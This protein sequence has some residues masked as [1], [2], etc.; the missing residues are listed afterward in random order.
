MSDDGYNIYGVITGTLGL[1]ALF[2]LTWIYTQLPWRK[3]AALQSFMDRTEATF[4]KGLGQA[5]HT[6]EEDLCHFYNTIWS[7][8]ASIEN[9]RREVDALPTWTAQFKGW[10]DGVSKNIDELHE[11]VHVLH[12]QLLESSSRDRRRLAELGYTDNLARFSGA[13][14]REFLSHVMTFARG[15]SPTADPEIH[16]HDRV[17]PSGETY[18]P[19][20]S[21]AHTALPPPQYSQDGTDLDS[22]P[23]PAPDRSRYAP[24]LDDRIVQALFHAPHTAVSVPRG[25]S[26]MPL[27]GPGNP[28]ASFPHSLGGTY[29]HN[30]LALVVN[31]PLAQERP[32]PTE[33]RSLRRE[34]LRRHSQEL[35]AQS[36]PSAQSPLMRQKGYERCRATT[37][38]GELPSHYPRSRGAGG[39][40]GIFVGARPPSRHHG[41][42]ARELARNAAYDGDDESDG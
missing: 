39:G 37:C 1:V 20:A 17:P 15:Q 31:V 8:T 3:L 42:A 9:M 40:G 23:D 35:Y 24:V 22:T 36:R 16:Y 27:N 10:W 11:E 13:R 25:V 7:L 28:N 14:S 29:I 6:Q 2:N 26:R 38:T 41:K 32:L 19:A 34:M 12:T 30:Q 5:L 21:I 18:P 4:Y 33:Y